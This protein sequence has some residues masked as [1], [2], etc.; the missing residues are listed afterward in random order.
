MLPPAPTL[1]P[2]ES[3]EGTGGRWAGLSVRSAG[4]HHQRDGL[5]G[6]RGVAVALDGV[7]LAADRFQL[8]DMSGDVSAQ[9]SAGSAPRR[10]GGIVLSAL[11]GGFTL[12]GGLLLPFSLALKKSAMDNAM[13]SSNPNA[14]SSFRTA[15]AKAR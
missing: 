9:V 2:T 11:G 5:L 6:D 12:A 10:A 13:M 7:D 3:G 4:R 1:T 8:G 14:R 15:T